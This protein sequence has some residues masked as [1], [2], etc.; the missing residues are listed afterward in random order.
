MW[1]GQINAESDEQQDSD[2]ELQV[3]L[4]GVLIF[5]NKWGDLVNHFRGFETG[6]LLII[7]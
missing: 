5:I 6:D 2:Q 4:S 3:S 1:I 7:C